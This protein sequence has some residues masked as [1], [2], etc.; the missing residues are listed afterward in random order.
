MSAPWILSVK[1]ITAVLPLGTISRVLT[2]SPRVWG[3]VPCL[4][5]ATVPMERQPNNV[6]LAKVGEKSWACVVL[7]STKVQKGSEK[8]LQFWRG[9]SPQLVLRGQRVPAALRW[10]QEP[11]V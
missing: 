10:C 2:G 9:L 7:L 8:G 3:A 5:A 6:G 4:R 11:E 1:T